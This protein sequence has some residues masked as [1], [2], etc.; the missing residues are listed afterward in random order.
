M[1]LLLRRVKPHPVFQSVGQ[2]VPDEDHVRTLRFSRRRR[3]CAILGC[4]MHAA[5]P[6]PVADVVVVE[7]HGWI[8]AYCG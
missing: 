4:V 5:T 1:C 7:I 3:L 8:G 2:S 6:Q